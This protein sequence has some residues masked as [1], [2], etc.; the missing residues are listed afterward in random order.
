MLQKL[1]LMDPISLNR[2][3]KMKTF[4]LN[5]L[6]NQQKLYMQAVLPT[7]HFRTFSVSLRSETHVECISFLKKTFARQIFVSTRIVYLCRVLFFLACAVFL[8]M[9]LLSVHQ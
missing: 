7:K 1:L 9:L 6:V 4:Q 3:C 2:K 8:I 5:S